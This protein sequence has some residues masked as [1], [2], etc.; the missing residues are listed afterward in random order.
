M[1]PELSH[2][3]RTKRLLWAILVCATAASMS[4]NIAQAALSQGVLQAGGPVIAAAIPPLALLS[5]THLTGMW[6]R[7]TTRGL[8][9]W[10]FLIA[11]AAITLAAFR[12][13]FEAQRALAIQYGYS[14]AD[15]ALFPLILDG[16]IAVATL[17]LVVLAR[18]DESLG[19]PMHRSDE[20]HGAEVSTHASL[21]R[22][23]TST[24]PV[25]AAPAAVN[26]ASL[27]ASAAA[28][29]LPHGV[30]AGAPGGARHP[31]ESRAVTAPAGDT[32]PVTS[33]DA[34]D[35]AQPMH[36]PQLGGSMVAGGDA[37][38]QVAHHL[39]DSGRT[40]A[41]LEAVHRVLVR[42][43]SGASSRSVAAEVGLS[44][45]TV[46]RIS[47]AAREVHQDCTV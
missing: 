14:A 35:A 42:S 28:V 41:P 2:R 43:A 18:T 19:A 27:P 26:G 47:R 45:S 39:I 8:V 1:S 33:G 36:A 44:Y 30:S 13:S 25:Q 20:H 6:S 34:G 32:V 24:P 5:L 4:G 10:C 23:D 29:G 3:R 31:V 38:L 37:V 46:Q 22:T 21:V 9:Y 16:L 15:A 12:L 7:I 11:V 17:G 40:T